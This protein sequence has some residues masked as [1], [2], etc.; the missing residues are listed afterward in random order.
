MMLLDPDSATPAARACLMPENQKPLLALAAT[1]LVLA[2]GLMLYI[3]GPAH[4]IA[5]P[6]DGSSAGYPILDGCLT[7]YSQDDVELRLKAWSAEQ[8]ALYRAIHLGPDMILPWVYSGF[9]FVTAVLLFG[10][11]FPGRT[12]WPGLLVL[13]ILTLAADYLEN[14]LISF[15][16]LSPVAPADASTIAWASRATVCKWGLVGMNTLVLVVGVG[17]CIRRRRRFA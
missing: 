13:P 16:I 15:V 3:Q 5:L 12:L 4:L 8:K 10:R 17:L 6:A 2:I 9:Y 11:T 1:L 7:G 14:Y